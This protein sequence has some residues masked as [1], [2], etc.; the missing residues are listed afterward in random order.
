MKYYLVIKKEQSNSICN[1]VGEPR[2]HH[3]KWTKS[4]KGQISPISGVQKNDT[5]N[6]LTKQK[7]IYTH[8]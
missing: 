8:T 2:D 6:L 3:T 4:D 5:K 1:N 7:Q